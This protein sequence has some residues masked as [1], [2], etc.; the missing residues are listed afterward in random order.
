MASGLETGMRPENHVRQVQN[1]I[2][3]RFVKPYTARVT[4]RLVRGFANSGNGR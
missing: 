4:H 1:E 2:N 3:V